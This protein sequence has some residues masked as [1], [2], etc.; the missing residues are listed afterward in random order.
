[1]SK[2][3]KE[4]GWDELVPGAALFAF[5]ANVDYLMAETQP[6]DRIYA[7]T[8]SKNAYVGDWRVFKP[9]WNSE[10]CIDCQNCWLFCP[11]TAIISRN[12]EMVGVDYDH[13][14]GC[15][16]CVEVC[17]TNPKSL[18]MFNETEKNEN[19]LTKWPEKKKKGEEE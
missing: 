7:E 8:N 14:K 12:K 4:M 16:I 6:E 2:S 15:G 9:V 13:C 17:P 10:L 5:N 1:M 3:I 11:D 18:L 19:A